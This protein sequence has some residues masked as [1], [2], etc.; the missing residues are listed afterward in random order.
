MIFFTP[1]PSQ[2]YPGVATFIQQ[3]IDLDVLSMS[4]RSDDFAALHRQTCDQL[5]LLLRIPEDFRIFFISSAT[6]GFERVLQSCVKEKSFHFVNGAFSKRFYETGIQLGLQSNAQIREVGQGFDFDDPEIEA[7]E[8]IC[9]VHNE[10]STG[11]RTALSNLYTVK[12]RNPLLLTV[13]DMVSS[14]PTEPVDFKY[15]DGVIFSVQKGF[16]IPSGL[17]VVI[18]S[19]MM[20]DRAHVLAKDNAVPT[21]FHNLAMMDPYFHKQMT[22][23]TPN[24]LN[25]YLL[26]RVAKAMNDYGRLR[27][28]DDTV[29]KA[30]LIYSCLDR[31]NLLL[32]VVLDPTLRS[33]TMIVLAVEEEVQSVVL[34]ALRGKGFEVGLGYGSGKNSQLRISNFP[35]HSLEMVEELVSVI[36]E[37]EKKLD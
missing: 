11:V 27:I 37:I 32:P 30:D 9:L 8:M 15:V 26:G 17:G 21:T 34:Q 19:P 13:V 33:N 6:E 2:L 23:E 20:M 28:F 29:C 3:A 18:A 5:R 12:K 31:S 14:L 35:A 7:S 10:S 22:P 24:V 36:V 16:G 1:G 4:H 25:I